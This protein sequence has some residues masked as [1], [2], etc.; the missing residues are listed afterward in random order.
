MEGGGVVPKRGR[1]PLAQMGRRC[2]ALA[3]GAFL[4]GAGAAIS[5]PAFAIAAVMPRA[6]RRD[7]HE[8]WA[9]AHRQ[10]AS[11]IVAEWCRPCRA[12]HRA[13]R[14]R[15]R[16]FD[17]ELFATVHRR[18][19]RALLGGVHV[20]PFERGARVGRGGRPRPALAVDRPELSVAASWAP[21][22]AGST[23]SSPGCFM[24][25]KLSEYPPRLALCAHQAAAEHAG[26]KASEWERRVLLDARGQ[27]DRLRHLRRTRLTNDH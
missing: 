11:V 8:A 22:T 18:S 10:P 20:R 26:V 19:A 16:A 15:A 14:A 23:T 4:V 5:M 27:L 17:V 3:A 2:R 6:R 12:L 1:A 25:P 13:R 9:P 7:C 24:R 21:G